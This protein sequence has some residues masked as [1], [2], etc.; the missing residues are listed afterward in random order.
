MGVEDGDAGPPL[1]SFVNDI[2]NIAGIATKPVETGHNQFVTG[3]EKFEDGREFGS[4][5]P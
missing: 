3:P 2:E 5:C 4:A 1:L